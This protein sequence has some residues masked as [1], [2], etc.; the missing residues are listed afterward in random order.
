VDFGAFVEILQARKAG[1]YR[2]LAEYRVNRV[3]DVVKVGDEIMVMVIEVD[4]Q[5]R[6]NLSRR[7]VLEGGTVPP[8][9]ADRVGEAEARRARRDGTNVTAG[10]LGP[11]AAGSRGQR[12]QRSENVRRPIIPGEEV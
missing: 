8:K 7:V 2:D 10:S 3:D 1:A 5:G 11:A 9:S 12:V 4:F 6:V